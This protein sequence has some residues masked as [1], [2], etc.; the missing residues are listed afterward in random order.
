V[1]EEVKIA[2]WLVDHGLFSSRSQAD[3]ALKQGRVTVNGRVVTRDGFPVRP[4]DTIKVF[5]PEEQYVSRAGHKLK[6]ALYAFSIDLQDKVVL[7]IGASTGGFTDCCLQAG[8]KRVYAYDVGHGQLA[9]SLRRDPRVI[10]REGINARYLTPEDVPEPVDFICM[11]VSFISCRLILP[12]L[13]PLLAPGKQAVILFKPQFEVGPEAVGKGGIV[14]DQ[15]AVLAALED[16]QSLLESLKCTQAGL[17]PSPLKGADGNQ[18]YLLYVI[19]E[20]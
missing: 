12:A 19:K 2:R 5:L 1:P 13:A 6:A 8:A 11:D 4:Q 18:E 20:K 10:S 14:T 16:C 17:L 7:D 9:G 15:Q 3:Q